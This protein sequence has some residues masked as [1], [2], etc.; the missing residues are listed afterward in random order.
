MDMMGM[1][2]YFVWSYEVTVLFK[3]WTVSGPVGYFMTC[4]LVMLMAVTA[5]HLKGTLE[6]MQRPRD[7]SDRISQTLL[8]GCVI[9]ISYLLMLVSMT[10]NVGLFA[11][12]IAGHMIGYYVTSSAAHQPSASPTGCTHF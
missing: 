10:F 2:A 3:E 12:V 8:Y 7:T 4:G 1:S 11:S 6:T 5:Q 9:S